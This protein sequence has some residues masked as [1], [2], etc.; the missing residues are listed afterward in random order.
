[1]NPADTE[2]F[3]AFFLDATFWV[4]V[5]FFVRVGMLLGH[6]DFHQQSRMAVA[7]DSLVHRRESIFGAEVNVSPSLDQH[8][9]GL[10]STRFTLHGEGQGSFCE[11]NKHTTH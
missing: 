9:D 2:T 10:A 1:M 5:V 6:V 7:S 8:P 3:T 4:S 11:E